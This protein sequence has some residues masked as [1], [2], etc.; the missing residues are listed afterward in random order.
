MVDCLSRAVS[1]HDLLF[2][3]TSHLGFQCLDT[4][5]QHDLYFGHIY[6]SFQHQNPLNIVPLLEFRIKEQL[7]YMLDKLC[8]LYNQ[9]KT[10]LK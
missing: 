10:L 8:V 6:K 5:Y 4:Q 2:L 1:F 3:I 7:V 9:E